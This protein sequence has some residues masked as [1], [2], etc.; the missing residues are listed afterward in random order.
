MGVSVKAD[1]RYGCIT[2]EG[3]K[4]YMARDIVMLVM[5]A[6]DYYLTDCMAAREQAVK[7]SSDTE[8][9]S[10]RVQW[11]LWKEAALYRKGSSASADVASADFPTPSTY[12]NADKPKAETER[13]HPST[14]DIVFD[15][16]L[17]KS[18][19]TSA[20]KVVP[21]TQSISACTTLLRQ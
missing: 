19:S 10:S 1:S 7:E 8:V 5:Q 2:L 9:Y 14:L 4:R 18:C 16:Q 17:G 6:A 20:R 3:G 11:I 12:T 21:G 13:P 15:E